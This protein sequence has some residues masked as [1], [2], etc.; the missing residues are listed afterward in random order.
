MVNAFLD[1]LEKGS[2]FQGAKGS[3][4]KKIEKES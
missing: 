1:L 3:R 4:E 2:R